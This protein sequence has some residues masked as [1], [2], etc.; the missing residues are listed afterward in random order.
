MKLDSLHDMVRD[1][2][3][4]TG[5]RVNLDGFFWD[6][7][8]GGFHDGYNE[9]F[10]FFPHV[11]FVFWSIVEHA[12]KRYFSINQTYG[13]FHEMCPYMKE[14]M[15]LNGLTEIITRTTRPPKVHERRWGMK[16]LKELDYTF[17][18]RRYHVMLSDI[19]HLN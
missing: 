11:G 15:H 17:Q 3:R 13:K 18:G 5:E 19:T 1:Y 7:K 4:R 16:H 8:K 2:A 12:G 10:K 14:V 6:E 9:Y